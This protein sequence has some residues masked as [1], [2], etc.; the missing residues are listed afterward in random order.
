MK[1]LSLIR[2][3]LLGLILCSFVIS[4]SQASETPKS[5]V[6]SLHDVL[7]KVMQESN[8][9]G[10]EGR[11][12]ELQPV[13]ND[14]FDFETIARVVLGR[15]WKKLDDSQKMQ[16]IQVFTELSTAVY[17]SRFDSFADQSFEYL[18]DKEMK[19][20]RILV[21]TQLITDERVVPFN[22]VLQPAKDKWR[23]INVIVDG[24]SD[25]SLKRADYTTIMKSDGFETLIDKIKEKIEQ[26]DNSHKK[27]YTEA[28]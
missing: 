1:T 16:F 10:Y 12:N 17:A 21:K 19:K 14:S 6:N 28:G 8:E 24:V 2:Q 26:A 4:N 22:Y 13:V 15:Y 18:D 5:V 23:I 25:L 3:T 20:G 9:L 7:I 11:Y 27:G